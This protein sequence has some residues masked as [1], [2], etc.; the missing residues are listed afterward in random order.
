MLFPGV[1]CFPL[2]VCPKENRID[3]ADGKRMIGKKDQMKLIM[4]GVGKLNE[5][6]MSFVTDDGVIKYL[7]VLNKKD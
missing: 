1:S 3:E 7:K 2:S 5:E 4:R 6:D